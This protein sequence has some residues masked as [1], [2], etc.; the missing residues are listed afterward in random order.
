[1][2]RKT[3]DC[4]L[5][6]SENECTLAISGEPDDVVN[7]AAE[8]AVTVHGH[9]DGPELREMLR[10]ALADNSDGASQA[11]AF[12]QLFEFSTDRIQE[13]SG[14]Q[15]RFAAAIGPK[16]TTRWS[17]L[18]TDRD[19]PRTYIAIVE[20]PSYE[21]AMANSDDPATGMF[22]KELNAICTVA[23]EFRNLD[24]EVARPY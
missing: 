6:P 19:R 21:Q 4:R 3:I 2:S 16:R 13:W 10:G 17:V 1:M 14:I 20:F 9:E 24:V 18:G 15:D 11:G 7:A 23:P 22:L 8:H 5:T 12:V